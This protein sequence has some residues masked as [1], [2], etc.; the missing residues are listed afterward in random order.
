MNSSLYNEFAG[1]MYD[2]V[3]TWLVRLSTSMIEVGEELKVTF[4]RWT[5]NRGGVC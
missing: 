1:M 3:H 5:E 2:M 4:E